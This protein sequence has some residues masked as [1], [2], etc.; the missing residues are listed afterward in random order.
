MHYINYHDTKS[1]VVIF[2]PIYLYIQRG[3]LKQLVAEA[4]TNL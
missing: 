1:H 4:N 3:K 2:I